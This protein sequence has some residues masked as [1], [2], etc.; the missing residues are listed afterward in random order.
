VMG[1]KTPKELGELMAAVYRAKDA[2]AVGDLY[3]A[4]AILANS[5]AGYSIV[6]RDAI[7][8][9]VTENFAIDVEWFDERDLKSVETGDYAFSHSTF[10][11]RLTLPDGTQKEGEG[12]GTVVF[13]RGADGNW[14]CVIDQ[15]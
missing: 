2:D 8:E 9:K 1:A 5:G 7:V 6:G 11:H 4:D 12:R 14:R 3:E 13:H 15:A 10:Q